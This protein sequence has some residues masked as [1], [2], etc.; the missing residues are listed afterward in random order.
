MAIPPLAA[1]CPLACTSRWT[2]VAPAP[3]AAR[4][5]ASS[6][7]LPSATA[8]SLALLAAPSPLPAPSVLAR[9]GS[10][11]SSPLSASV[12]FTTSLNADS[13]PAVLGFPKREADRPVRS[14][15][16]ARAEGGRGAVS[17]EA[18]VAEVQAEIAELEGELEMTFGRVEAAWRRYHRLRAALERL[19]EAAARETR[20]AGLTGDRSTAATT[21]A[22]SASSGG[23][24]SS[25]GSGVLT[26]L[27][28]VR[29]ERVRV[30]HALTRAETR[31]GVLERL[32]RSIA[33]AISS[34]ERRILAAAAA[35][36]PPVNQSRVRAAGGSSSSVGAAARA[37][38]QGSEA[39]WQQ[40]ALGRRERVL[41]MYLGEV[42]ALEQEVAHKV[43]LLHSALQGAGGDEVGGEHWEVRHRGSEGAGREGE[44]QE[45][46]NG[47]KRGSDSVRGG[48][49]GG[50]GEGGQ[51]REQQSKEGRDGAGQGGRGSRG[52]AGRSEV[53]G[54]RAKL[55]EARR[56]LAQLQ[57]LKKSLRSKIL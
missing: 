42:Q 30:L 55:Q 33:K 44:R 53:D 22:S 7:P 46:G 12:L 43:A 21:A 2:P 6:S 28:R 32:V 39:T 38:G 19:D 47:E 5:A 1:R 25:R 52:Q 49:E 10:S 16:V 56:L 20:R 51:R 24:N 4:A 26:T 9:C 27:E 11:L 23:S 35:S 57:A 34:R 45:A 15:H 48:R 17:D 50:Q 3:S 14:V 13:P 54:E 31:A 41:G 29:V 18:T 36:R 40:R 8:S 37:C